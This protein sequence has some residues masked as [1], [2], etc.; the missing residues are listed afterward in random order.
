MAA[1]ADQGPSEERRRAGNQ[2]EMNDQAF[3]E[4]QPPIPSMNQGFEDTDEIQQNAM[5]SSLMDDAIQNGR[6]NKFI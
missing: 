3:M 1:Q 5:Q 2:L 4:S 6:Q